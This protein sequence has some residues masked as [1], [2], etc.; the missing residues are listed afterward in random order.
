M[1][2]RE[3]P[4]SVVFVLEEQLNREGTMVWD[5]RNRRA[6]AGAAVAGLLI[7]VGFSACGSSEPSSSSSS[8]P[9]AEEQ[10]SSTEEQPTLKAPDGPEGALSETSFGSVEQGM[11]IEEAIDLWGPPNDRHRYP[12]CELDPSAPDNITLT[13]NAP[14]GEVILGFNGE[15]KRLESY[16]TSSKHFPTKLGV[17]VGDSFAV[18]EGSEGAAL[19]PVS[20]GVDS[21][22]QDG[23]WQT[24]DPSRASQLFAI[25]GGTIT[26]IS[27]GVIRFCE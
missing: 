17:R 27:G 19:T 20:L 18:L 7:L 22:K 8:P 24:G 26:M 10:S 4:R 21:T 13:W 2:Y 25:A 9:S 3:R 23:Y 14:D 16:R 15:T 5:I 1:S 11:E 12:G 6:I